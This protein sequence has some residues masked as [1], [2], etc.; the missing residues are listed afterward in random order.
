M[1]FV[2]LTKEEEKVLIQ[3]LIKKLLNNP[4]LSPWEKEFLA[5]IN[6]QILFRDLSEKQLNVLNKLKRKYNQKA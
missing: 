5:S 6:D 1:V 2:Q 4:G 3:K